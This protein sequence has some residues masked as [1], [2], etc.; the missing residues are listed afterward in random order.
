M[1][2]LLL[3]QVMQAQALHL[4]HPLHLKFYAVSCYKLIYSICLLDMT[5]VGN[6][7]TEAAPLSQL[8]ILSKQGIQFS[9]RCIYCFHNA[10]LLVEYITWK[11]QKRLSIGV[12]Y[13]RM[14]LTLHLTF[15]RDW[16]QMEPGLCQLIRYF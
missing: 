12:I 1:S 10:D 3:S 14:H 16:D 6:K 8:Y 5:K 7:A 4:T 2:V 13:Y 9:Y 11:L 15:F